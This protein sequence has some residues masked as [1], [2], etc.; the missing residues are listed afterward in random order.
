MNK[1]TQRVPKQK[2]LRTP[3]GVIR[4]VLP[5][6]I[7]MIWVL[8]A[9]GLG[10]GIFSKMESSKYQVSSGFPGT[11]GDYKKDPAGLYSTNIM[12]SPTRPYTTP[13]T[14]PCVLGYPLISFPSYPEIAPIKGSMVGVVGEPMMLGITQGHFE[15]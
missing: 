12:D 14:R 13:A 10:T 15:K 11:Y 4:R 2:G 3:N 6:E 1:L 8:G 9:L 7:L 5:A